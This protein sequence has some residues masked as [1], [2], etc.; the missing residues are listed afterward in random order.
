MVRKRR[1]VI[2]IGAQGRMLGMALAH[3][4]RATPAPQ[5]ARPDD[6][7]ASLTNERGAHQPRHNRFLPSR[8]PNTQYP[9][10]AA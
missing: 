9:R 2:E 6:S 8:L 5:A 10:Y 1:A 4:S 7:V 3:S